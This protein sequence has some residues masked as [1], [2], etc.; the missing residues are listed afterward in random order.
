[1]QARISEQPEHKEINALKHELQLFVN[2]VIK[3]EKPI[4]SGADGLR[5]LRVAELIIK[6]IEESIANA[7]VN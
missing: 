3:N 6:K 5:N 4:V 7:K 2:S 1:V